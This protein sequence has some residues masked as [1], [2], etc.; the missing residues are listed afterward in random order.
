M[1][2]KIFI[3]QSESRYLKSLRSKLKQFLKQT[4]HSNKNSSIFLIAAGEACSNSI[5]HAY[6]GSAGHKIRITVQDQRAKKVFKVRDYGQKINLRKV[7]PPKLPPRK[8]HG[9]GI[10]LLKTMMDEV[11]YNTHHLRG[12]ELIVAKYKGGNTREDSR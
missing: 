6:L 2:Q 10:Y 12:N 1:K 9:L 8:P 7:K 3:I 4:G 11:K 5:R